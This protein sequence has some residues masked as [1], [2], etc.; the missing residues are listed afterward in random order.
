[1]SHEDF[2]AELDALRENL[3][4]SVE[5][6]GASKSVEKISYNIDLAN[7]ICEQVAQGKSLQAISRMGEM[8]S[9]PTLIRWSKEN[10]ELSKMLRAVRETRA[11]LFEDAAI[12]AAENASGKDADRLKV[13]TYKWAAEV[14]DPTTYGK[15]VAHSGEVKGGITLQVVTGF[16]APN[17]WQT[18][19]KLKAD[20][21][22]DREIEVTSEEV[23]GRSKEHGTERSNEVDAQRDQNSP[24]QTQVASGHADAPVSGSGSSEPGLPTLRA[25]PGHENFSGGEESPPIRVDELRAGDTEYFEAVGAPG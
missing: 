6:I 22:I 24:E 8:P 18:P 7:R 1:M 5:E 3:P 15:K 2:N 12:E 10:A 20:G 16:G 25:D 17:A 19:P 9:Y 4:A 23:N 21:T 14:N 13:E 11:R